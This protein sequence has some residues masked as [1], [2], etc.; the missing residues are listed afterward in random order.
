[1]GNWS[2]TLN[3]FLKQCLNIWIWHVFDLKIQVYLVFRWTWK[4]KIENWVISKNFIETIIRDAARI[5]PPDWHWALAPHLPH[6]R[7]YFLAICPIWTSHSLLAQSLLNYISF[8]FNKTSG[9][10]GS[11]MLVSFLFSFLF[12]SLYSFF[13]LVFAVVAGPLWGSRA[14]RLSAV[15]P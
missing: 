6:R 2:V 13:F 3:P 11:T 8:H 5:K 14:P 4:L 12:S 15:I 7:L 9:A 1:M 10:E